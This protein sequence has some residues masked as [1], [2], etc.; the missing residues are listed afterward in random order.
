MKSFPFFALLFVLVLQTGCVTGRR[1]FE[2]PV[3][4]SNAKPDA[5][6]GE[7]YLAAVTDDRVFENK[8]S[9]PSTP[10][11]DGDVQSLSAAEK[12]HMIGRQRNGFGR[13][14]GDI[15]LANGETVTHRVRLLVEEGLRRRGY[16]ISQDPNAPT[17][18]SV[19]IDQFWAWMAPGMFA[20]TFEA[21]VGTQVVLKD[22]T[23]VTK[24]YAY[25]H[26][27]NH[28][29]VVKDG[30]W[31]EAFAPAFDQYLASLVHELGTAP[32]PLAPPAAPT[33]DLYTE[34][35][36]LDELRAQKI[37]TEEEFQAQK[38]KLLERN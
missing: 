38:K 27:L 2:V 15:A 34:L 14:M 28:G 16:V 29:Q 26:G 25:G 3:P 21:K 23:G 12:D 31:Q 24:V 9:D 36:K 37:L 10:S 4:V 30:N 13:A 5:V 7:V 17:S 11:I 8:P 22:R 32:A 6:R 1:T 35:K 20:L 19:S 18:A 33:T